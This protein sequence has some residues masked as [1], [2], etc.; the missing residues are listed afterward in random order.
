VS[1]SSVVYLD[2]S[3][4]VKLIFDEPETDA[5]QRFLA[6]RPSRFSSVVARAE[7]TRAA[8]SVGDD[9]VVGRAHDVLDGLDFIELDSQTI[10][11]A[12]G[13][14]PRSVRTLEAIHLAA[15]LSLEPDLAGIVVYDTRL[16]AAARAAGLTVWAPA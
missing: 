5:L 14:E 4:I 1:V 15:A 7:V 6:D 8:R 2:S 16:A 9:L 10:R 13:V 3:A 12:A 11:R